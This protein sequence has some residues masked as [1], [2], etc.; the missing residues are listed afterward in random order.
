MAASLMLGLMLGAVIFQGDDDVPV[1]MSASTPQVSDEMEK[2]V[3]VSEAPTQDA[4]ATLL[5]EH[6]LS[7]PQALVVEEQR[8]V[9]DDSAAGAG[10]SESFATPVFR[11]QVLPP[12]LPTITAQDVSPENGATL[13]DVLSAAAAARVEQQQEE[14]MVTGSRIR[15]STYRD[16]AQA[17][18]AEI[19]RLTEQLDGIGTA[20]AER[21]PELESQLEFERDEFR[22]TFPEV[23]LDE[24][25]ED[26]AEQ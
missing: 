23:D 10:N 11:E 12:P 18:V 14:I 2:T 1:A 19:A 3:T 24:A 25:L 6:A 8:A 4:G 7:P 9:G 15:R 16:D 21:R 20:E 5:D 17:W 13:T 22:Q 26:L